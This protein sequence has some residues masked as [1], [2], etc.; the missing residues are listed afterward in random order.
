MIGQL[1]LAFSARIFATP[2]YRKLGPLLPPQTRVG[3]FRVIERP[4]G[5]EVR[6]WPFPNN[7]KEGRRHLGRPYLLPHF[8]LAT[9]QRTI[10]PV[11]PSSDN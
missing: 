8:S 1:D 2:C 3:E 9:K 4:G 6:P 7:S 11:S 5:R 10:H